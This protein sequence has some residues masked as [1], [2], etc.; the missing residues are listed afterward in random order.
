MEL[1]VITLERFVKGEADVINSLFESGL[2]TLHLRKPSGTEQEIASLLDAINADYH[3]RI[4]LHDHFQLT[5]MYNLKG[6][7]INKRNPY[8]PK[9]EV[10]SVSCSCHSLGEISLTNQYDYVFL[11]PIFDS[12]SKTGYGR[13]F[14]H[15]QLVDMHA[16]GIIN[17]KVVALGGI[18]PETIPVAA[19]YGFGGVAVLGGLWGD[20]EKDEDKTIVIER[21]INLKKLCDQNG[22]LIIYFTPDR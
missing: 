11:S 6:V 13:A 1:I 17:E 19:G 3:C 2:I 15:K 16:A 5:E 12:I 14:T 20:Y 22:R 8:L 10:W 21:F 18:C 7:H 4:M 9:T